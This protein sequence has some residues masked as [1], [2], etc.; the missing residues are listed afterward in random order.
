MI[1]NITFDGVVHGMIVR[2]GYRKDG[3]TFF[4]P[5]S[6]SQQLGYMQHPKGLVIRPHMHNEI[7]REII[8]TQEV[9]II[10]KGK[11]R[12]DFYTQDC[13]YKGSSILGPGDIILL[14]SGGHGFEVIEDVEMF[15]VKQGPYKGD[16][17]KL[18]FDK[19]PGDAIKIID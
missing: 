7:P 1:Q 11:L 17:D 14:A 2:S 16:I 15:E 9:L 10:R 4:T 6:Y 8:Y 3:I 5:D 19:L 18:H 13:T 12:V